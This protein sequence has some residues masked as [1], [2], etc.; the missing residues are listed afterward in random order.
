MQ[1]NK[2]YSGSPVDPTL[3]PV[4]AQRWLARALPNRLRLPASIRLEQEGEMEIRG[5]W[6]PFKATGVYQAAP[7]AF[8]WQAKLKMLP[9]VWVLAEDGHHKGQGWGGARLW[10]L[11]PMGRRTDPQVL[12][13]QLVRNLGELPWLP[14][15]ALIDAS[16]SWSTIAENIFEVC[17]SQGGHEALVRFEID[18]QG[19]IVKASSP[20]RLYDAPSGYESAPW[21]YEFSEHRNFQG[22]RIPAAAVARF[23]KSAGAWEY[24]RARL[25][26]SH[27]A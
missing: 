4:A 19:D 13:S 18:D 26:A 9:G 16:L 22:V 15:F 21:H 12:A 1:I 10:G 20:S 7:L 27:P 5:R 25:T 2:E 3:L 8:N 23:E 14:A 24:F 17:A 11:L 6:T